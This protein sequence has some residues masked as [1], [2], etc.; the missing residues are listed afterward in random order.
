MKY[1][2]SLLILILVGCQPNQKPPKEFL[3]TVTKFHENGMRASN[4]QQ[5]QIYKKEYQN[6]LAGLDSSHAKKLKAF[7]RQLETTLTYADELKAMTNL[8]DKN[9]KTSSVKINQL[10]LVEGKAT[11]LF[12]H[13]RSCYIL[14]TAAC[15][16]PKA[17]QDDLMFGSHYR[18]PQQSDKM[19][20]KTFSNNTPGG[21][22]SYLEILKT[23]LILLANSVV[24]G[25]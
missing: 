14:G 19:K 25:E 11:L 13:V 22:T 4:L 21:V 24:S 9:D 17:L 7:N 16:N 18:N 3:N 12:S 6:T 23:Q 10:F 8:I 5:L 20:V 15:L 2:S 1:L